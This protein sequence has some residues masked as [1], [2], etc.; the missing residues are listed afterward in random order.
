MQIRPATSSD[1]AA[2][3]A[4]Y[5]PYVQDTLVSFEDQPPDATEMRARIEA[6]PRLPW[7]VAVDETDV[8]GYAYASSHRPRAG[9]RWSADVSVYLAE[10]AQRRGLGGRLYEE[11]LAALRQL[12]YV[13]AYAGIALPNAGSVALHEAAGFRLVGIYTAVGFKHGT[14]VDVGWWHLALRDPPAE[15]GEPAEWVSPADEG[16]P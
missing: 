6:R 4:V 7:L 1:A 16:R 9:Y 12:G 5:A 2:I 11:L 3:A 15:P 14:W 8:V 13:N 10:A